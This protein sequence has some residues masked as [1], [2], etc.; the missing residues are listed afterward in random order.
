MAFEAVTKRYD[1]FTALKQVTLDIFDNEFF[2]LLGPS[3]CG[4]TTLLRAIAGFEDIQA[5]SIR[6]FGEDIASLPPDKRS[7]NTVFQNY[8]LFPHMDVTTNVM[9]GLR[10]L[11]KDDAEARARAADVLA[12]VQLEPFADRMPSQLSGGQQQRVALARALAPNPR[13]LLLDEPLS[14]LDLKLRQAVR[15]ELQQLQKDTGITFIFVTHD[16]E[17]ALTMSD[18]IAV[19]NA[20]EVQQVGDPRQIY[21]EPDNPFVASFIGETNLLKVDIVSISDGRAQVALHSGAA[22][23]CSAARGAQPGPGHV[24]IR[25]ERV[26]VCALDQATLSGTVRRVVYLGTDMQVEVELAA[27]DAVTARIQNAQ[28]ATIPAIGEAVGLRFDAS[29]ARVLGA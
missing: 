12:L 4:K 18:R 20:G 17:E 26:E 8:A 25:P 1:T 29:A 5:G 21:E 22:L 28:G 24:S 6:L 19:I 3:G 10:M 27:G 14:A 13:V 11:G 23:S 9:F 16:Q 2:T 7:V 15:L